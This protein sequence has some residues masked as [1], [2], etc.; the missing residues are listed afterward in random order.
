MMRDILLFAFGALAGVLWGAV[1]VMILWRYRQ[2]R[3]RPRI[4]YIGDTLSS[5]A[6]LGRQDDRQ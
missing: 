4:V 1:C 3:R 6:T 2:W 5:D